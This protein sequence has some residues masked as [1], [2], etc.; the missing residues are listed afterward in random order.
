M[1]LASANPIIHILNQIDD[2]A[3]GETWTER[4]PEYQERRL[5]VRQMVLGT[6]VYMLKVRVPSV[7]DNLRVEGYTDGTPTP[8]FEGF[9]SDEGRLHSEATATKQRLPSSLRSNLVAALRTLPAG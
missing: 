4:Q 3:L 5:L 7:W 8:V 1:R 2:L 6:T 9:W